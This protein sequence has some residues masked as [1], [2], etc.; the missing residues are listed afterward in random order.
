MTRLEKQMLEELHRITD[1]RHQITWYPI[2][3]AGHLLNDAMVKNYIKSDIC[4]RELQNNLN[5]ISNTN[6]GMISYS[7]INIP[8]VYTQLVTITVHLYFIV[9]LF[10]RQFLNPT[11]YI[12][13]DGQQVPVEKGTLGAFNLCGYDDRKDFYFPF[14]TTIQFIFYFGWLKVAESLINPFGD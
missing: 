10:G 14:F 2:K 9:A 3:W 8:L 12:N 5:D 4:Y 13:R 6:A 7:W 1:H 11:M